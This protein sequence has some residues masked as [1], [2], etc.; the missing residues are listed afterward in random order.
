MMQHEIIESNKNNPTV[1]QTSL[2]K[3]HK[4]NITL[5]NYFDTLPDI[6]KWQFHINED[7]TKGTTT[8]T[9]TPYHTGLIS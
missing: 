1:Q 2:A 8:T 5:A 9:R 7:T 4:L 3:L 6:K